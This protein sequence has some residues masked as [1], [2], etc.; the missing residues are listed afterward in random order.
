M[1]QRLLVLFVL[2]ILLLFTSCGRYQGVEDT[3]DTSPEPI[4]TVNTEPPVETQ[5]PD[6]VEKSPFEDTTIISEDGKTI[7]VHNAQELIYYLESDKHFLL[8]PGD[9]DLYNTHYMGGFEP[10]LKDLKNVTLEGLGDE[11]VKFI[12]SD[13]YKDVLEIENCKGITLINLYLGHVP[14]AD[15]LCSGSVLYL[16]KCQGITIKNCTLF[17]CGMYGIIGFDDANLIIKDST[18][19]DC[20]EDLIDIAMSRRIL[21]DNCK[22]YNRDDEGLRFN[23]CQ[24]VDIKN[25]EFI[26]ELCPY[27]SVYVDY[28]NILQYP[29]NGKTYTINERE[30]DW[31]T[32]TNSSVTG[33]TA[34]EEINDRL[35]SLKEGVSIQLSSEIEFYGDENK[36]VYCSLMYKKPLL[37]TE[38]LKTINEVTSVL[39][40][41]FDSEIVITVDWPGGDSPEFTKASDGTIWIHCPYSSLEIILQDGRKYLTVQEAEGKFLEWILSENNDIDLIKSLNEEDIETYLYSTKI[42]GSKVYYLF[43]AYF[44]D[45]FITDVYVNAIDGSISESSDFIY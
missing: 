39:Q 15:E 35:N 13:I 30:Y 12:T 31:G 16:N 37:E 9:Y 34:Q 14:R 33:Y 28:E 40:D 8:M 22:F 32:L 38:Y 20:S 5:D 6:T 26:G 24:E 17:G 1:K 19:L 45:S 11:Q 44:K 27:P 25:C 2:I 10:V 3:P 7:T 21:L 36:Y 18:F 23:D 29:S 43:E 4:E 41:F 42:D